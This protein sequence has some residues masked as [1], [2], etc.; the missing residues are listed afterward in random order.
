MWHALSVWTRNYER[1]ENDYNVRLLIVNMFF[2][3]HAV[4]CIFFQMIK[5]EASLKII[6]HSVNEHALYPFLLAW[7]CV[8]ESISPSV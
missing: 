7:L 8:L 1:K 2:R 3:E 5:Q 6:S 4:L